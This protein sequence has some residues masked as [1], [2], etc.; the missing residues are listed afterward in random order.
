L[1][2]LVYVVQFF[3]TTSGHL[4]KREFVGFP[5]KRPAKAFSVLHELVC[6]HKTWKQDYNE[7]YER[8]LLDN[9]VYRRIVGSLNRNHTFP[10]QSRPADFG[11]PQTP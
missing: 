8:R 11:N 9:P 7:V 3:G 10:A 5:C 1:S 6:K 2:R 4:K